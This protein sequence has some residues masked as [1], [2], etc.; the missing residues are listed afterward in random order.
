MAKRSSAESVNKE[1][2]SIT[3]YMLLWGISV[4]SLN[5]QLYVYLMGDT[6]KNEMC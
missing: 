5:G 2:K 3:I 1:M 6:S 4:I